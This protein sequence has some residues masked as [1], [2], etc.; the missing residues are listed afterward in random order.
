[1]HQHLNFILVCGNYGNW[2]RGGGATLP[3]QIPAHA[4]VHHVVALREGSAETLAC[5]RLFCTVTANFTVFRPGMGRGHMSATIHLVSEGDQS[6]EPISQ[7]RRRFFS[8]AK[9]QVTQRE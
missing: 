8:Q 2:G 3:Q 6:S 9:M 5:L 7:P 4:P 1:M